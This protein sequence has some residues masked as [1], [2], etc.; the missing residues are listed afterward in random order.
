MR[1]AIYCRVSTEGQE[2]EGTSL[3]TQKEACL[4]VARE[5]GC[6]V[7]PEHAFL[8]VWSGAEMGRPMLDQVRGLVRFG[9][10]DALI[11][12]ST[13]RLA[14][15]P[16]HIAIIA[17]ECEKRGVELVFVTEPLDN[18]PEGKL[19][20][21]VKG[22]AAELEREII[23]E[24][25]LRGKRDHA[26]NGELATGGRCPY[27]YRSIEGKRVIDENEAEIVRR[28]F[29]WFA[30]D[31]FKLYRAAVELNR[32]KTPAPRGGK[33]MEH[34]VYRILNN[35]AY[36]GITYAFRY[37]VVEAKHPKLD[38][39]RYTKT[40]HVFRDASEWIEIPNATPPI[41]DETTWNMARQQ[42]QRNRERAPRNRKHDYLLTNGRLRCG[43]CG[44]G[45]VGSV[46]KKGNNDYLFYRCVPRVK[47]AL[48]TRCKGPTISAKKIESEVSSAIATILASPKMYLASIERAGKEPQFASLEAERLI[49]QKKLRILQEE[50]RRYLNLYGKG[51]I[52]DDL[53]GTEIA[54]VRRQRMPLQE[55]LEKLDARW[56]AL[57]QSQLLYDKAEH[58]L[59]TL[60]ERID[61]PNLIK[62]ALDALD[63][64][65][66]LYP[67]RVIHVQ[68]VVPTEVSLSYANP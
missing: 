48:Y 29:R 67:N 33:W 32:W 59:S 9:L 14:R 37:K 46:K 24:R 2:K 45:M 13:D 27:G 31:G 60:A 19:I 63:I 17:D 7:S 55:E 51:T 42:L 16:I 66:T 43:I 62:L 22:Y 36:K 23:K 57:E 61:D 68:G 5:R 26:R 39:R 1:A 44:Y 21:Y 35:P 6:D 4:K 47:P 25:T 18:S 53:L 34:T 40:T 20:L 8:E 41:V 30:S 56:K 10:I 54:R 50:E 58:F 28:I 49:V 12:Y 11:C 3:G 52:D 38:S 15:N 64:K 65:V